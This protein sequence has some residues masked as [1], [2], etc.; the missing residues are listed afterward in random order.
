LSERVLLPELSIPSSIIFLFRFYVGN[1]TDVHS[2][3]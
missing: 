2:L 1:V 3:S